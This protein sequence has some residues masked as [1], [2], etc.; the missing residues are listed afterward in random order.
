MRDRILVLMLS[1]S[2]RFRRIDRIALH[3]LLFWG[4]GGGGGYK[5]RSRCEPSKRPRSRALPGRPPPRE[6]VQ[7]GRS[8]CQPEALRSGAAPKARLGAAIK[9]ACQ[10]GVAQPMAEERSA[11]SSCHHC[12]FAQAASR[13]HT[14]THGKS[15]IRLGLVIAW[16][17]FITTAIAGGAR[18][19]ARGALR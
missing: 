18:G 7:G 19:S 11:V 2:V 16:P 14:P 4:G 17:A 10:K 9:V 12:I 6:P 8:A 3:R 5:V 13:T 1:R 15:R